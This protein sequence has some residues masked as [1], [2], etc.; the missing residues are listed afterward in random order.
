VLTIE[1]LVLH[2]KGAGLY[3]SP[4]EGEK[5]Y[6]RPCPGERGLK[7]ILSLGWKTKEWKKKEETR[8]KK[9]IAQLISVRGKKAC[10]QGREKNLDRAVWKKNEHEQK[11]GD[12]CCPFGKGRGERV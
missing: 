11:K 10:S 9:K 8:K 3:S 4:K 7:A 2:E 1:G 6:E 12:S 5:A